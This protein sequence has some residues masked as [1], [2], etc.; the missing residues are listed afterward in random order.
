LVYVVCTLVTKLYV[1]A[2]L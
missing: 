2:H 1:S